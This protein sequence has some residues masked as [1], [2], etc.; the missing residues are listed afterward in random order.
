MSKKDKLLRLF[1]DGRWHNNYE[2][3]GIMINYKGRIHDLRKEG[4]VFKRKR[5]GNTTKWAWQLVS[6]P[7]IKPEYRIEAN[8]QICFV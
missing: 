6:E 2:L 5:I 7:E 1:K 4:Y 3:V 8:G